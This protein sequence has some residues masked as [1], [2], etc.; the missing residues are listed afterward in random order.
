MNRV[1]GGGSEICLERGGGAFK[2]RD[3][4]RGRGLAVVLGAGAGGRRGGISAGT[5]LTSDERHAATAIADQV[6][7]GLLRFH[8]P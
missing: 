4:G 5:S 8:D 1:R 6:G 7:I 2:A 3:F